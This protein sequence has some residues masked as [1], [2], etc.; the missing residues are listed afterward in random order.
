MAVYLEG[1]EGVMKNLNKAVKHIEGKTLSGLIRGA[2]IIRR[3]MEDATPKVP[4]DTGNL[5][6]SFFVVTS[7]GGLNTKGLIQTTNP[8]WKTGK[9]VDVSKLGA[10]HSSVVSSSLSEA[11]SAKYPVVILGFTANYAVFVHENYNA[12]NWNRTGSGPG[13]LQ[14]AVKRSQGKIVAV[15]AEEAKV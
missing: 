3:S 2:I 11:K 8:E 4:V 12:K 9:N 1:L 6:A 13:F 14:A 5:R 7:K 10:N 15:I